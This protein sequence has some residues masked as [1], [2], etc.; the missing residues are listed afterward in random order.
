MLSFLFFVIMVQNYE[1][2]LNKHMIIEK[3]ARIIWFII[4]K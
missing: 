2:N 1:K 3:K 4:E